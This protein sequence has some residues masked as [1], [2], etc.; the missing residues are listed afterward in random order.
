[1]LGLNEH[2][3]AVIYNARTA[4]ELDLLRATTGEVLPPP[5]SVAD[6][7]RL[8][9]NA[10]PSNLTVGTSSDTSEAYVGDYAQL[11]MGSRT[12]LVLE[13]SREANVGATSMFTTLQSA[14]RVYLRCDFQVARPAA[15]RVVCGIR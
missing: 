4:G 8:V 11:L 12:E 10:I 6:L 15:F 3:N 2:P 5:G 7:Q 1:V 13:V 9:T 14:V